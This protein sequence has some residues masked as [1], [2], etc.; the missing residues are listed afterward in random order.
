MTVGDIIHSVILRKERKKTASLLQA[1]QS[2]NLISNDLKQSKAKIYNT[3]VQ[4]KE[5][6]T[7]Y[8]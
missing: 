3:N 5:I 8:G 1:L 6:M 2:Q 4:N 7:N